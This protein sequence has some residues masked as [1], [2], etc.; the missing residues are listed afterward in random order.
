[1][2]HSPCTSSRTS[3]RPWSAFAWR[4][5]QIF[6]KAEKAAVGGEHKGR[7]VTIECVAVSLHRAV[8]GKELLVLPESVGIGFDA[9]RIRS[10]EH[11]SELQSRFDL[12]CRLLL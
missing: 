2:R 9:L 1:M 10:E 12:V 6:E 4:P 3:R 5:V 11:T 7:G 8:E